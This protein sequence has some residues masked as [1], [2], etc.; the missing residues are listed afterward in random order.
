MV[1]GQSNLIVFN[2]VVV[3]LNQRSFHIFHIFHIFSFSQLV[4]KSKKEEISTK[5]M[6][7]NFRTR[8]FLHY[9]LCEC[10]LINTI[11]ITRVQFSTR[12]PYTVVARSEQNGYFS[13]VGCSF[14]RLSLVSVHAHPRPLLTLFFPK[15]SNQPSYFIY[16]PIY[17]Y[18]YMYIYITRSWG[19]RDL[20]GHLP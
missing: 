8:F 20:F 1:D 18:M 7:S 14:T 12:F 19:R 9:V 4:P 3:N 11:L 2:I 5:Y 17:I 15:E 10:Y 6:C 16:T 13:W